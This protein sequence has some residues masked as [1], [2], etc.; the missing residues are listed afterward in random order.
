MVMPFSLVTALASFMPGAARLMGI[1]CMAFD[2][3]VR[4]QG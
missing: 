2:P 4:V 1:F 3:G